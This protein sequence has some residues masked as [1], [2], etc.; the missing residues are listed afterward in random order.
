MTDVAERIEIGAIR[1]EKT[2]AWAI[3][4]DDVLFEDVSRVLFGRLSWWRLEILE[5][6]VNY[7]CGVQLSHADGGF[8]AFLPADMPYGVTT[9]S[10]ILNPFGKPEYKFEDYRRKEAP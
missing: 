3:Q 8:I 2:D 4:N 6:G 9:V 7:Q 1:I 10:N 5:G